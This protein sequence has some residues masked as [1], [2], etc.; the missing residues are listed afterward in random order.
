M[1]VRGKSRPCKLAWV[2]GGAAP[3]HPEC[4]PPCVVVRLSAAW[5][6]R[7]RCTSPSQRIRITKS[8]RCAKPVAQSSKRSENVVFG[9][10]GELAC[11]IGRHA[12]GVGNGT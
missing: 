5:R 8:A 12:L 1:G 9:T 6:P 4:G 2:G 10:Q 3:D 11:S 7:P